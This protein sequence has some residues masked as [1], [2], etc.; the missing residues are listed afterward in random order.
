MIR[1]RVMPN[2]YLQKLA[3]SEARAAAAHRR[4]PGRA[5]SAGPAASSASASTSQRARADSTAARSHF[6]RPEAATLSAGAAQ[7]PQARRG[8]V[9]TSAVAATDDAEHDPADDA[10]PP[11]SSQLQA[12]TSADVQGAEHVTNVAHHLEPATAG[13]TAVQAEASGGSVPRGMSLDDPG[14]LQQLSSLQ[15][16]SACTPSA[17]STADLNEAA[18]GTSR[19]AQREGSQA[20]VTDSAVCAATG[21]ASQ[22]AEHA[23]HAASADAHASLAPRAS[24]DSLQAGGVASDGGC[25]GL[26]TG[27]NSLGSVSALSTNWRDEGSD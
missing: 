10:A 7:T 2:R 26:L 25:G 22:Q 9:H 20:S 11:M 18:V 6:Q 15:P 3:E 4:E 17:G 24:I 8:G 21:Q 12:Q 27:D 5:H 1:P 13:S 14:V 23:M 19:R 16:P